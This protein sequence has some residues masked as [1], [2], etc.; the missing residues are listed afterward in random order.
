[1]H[2]IMECLE[3][4]AQFGTE[5]ENV[6]V[7]TAESLGEAAI[8]PNAFGLYSDAQYAAPGFPFAPYS[9]KAPLEWVEVI[10]V[11]TEQPRFIPVEFVYPRAKQH[12]QLLVAETSTGTAAHTS[13]DAACLAAFCELVER[14]SLL[15]FWHRQPPTAL[16]SIDSPANPAAHDLE[17]I[18]SK[19]FVVVLCE[20][21]YDLGIPCVLAL[22]MKGGRL[23]AG[24]GCHPLLQCAI[25]QALRE[26]GTSL[27]WQQ[28]Y[29]GSPRRWIAV[30]QVVLPKDHLT[31]YDG[32]PWH[33]LFC[34]TLNNAI[35][36]PP[37]HVFNDASADL[38]TAESLENVFGHLSSQNYSL[39]TCD[40]P[41]PVLKLYG[42]SVVRSFA[43]GLVPMY[44]GHDRIRFGARR[45]RTR[46]SPGRLCNLLP[47]F[48]P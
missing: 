36:L 24:A 18:R 34:Q 35:R 9:K 12:R 45:L 23:A 15:M 2:A 31:L 4:L 33:D 37:K 13:R 43:P 19:G 21:N 40:L 22:A 6:R 3:R 25:E 32:G 26:L 5:P 16:I 28:Q 38:S 41:H 42:V 8:S 10:E 1:M 47:H 7:A 20:L 44:F 39:F 48:F 46:E 27:K 29:E 30:Q 17:V 11:G 14:D